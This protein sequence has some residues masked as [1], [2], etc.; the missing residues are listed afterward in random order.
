MTSDVYKNHLNFDD[1]R[2]ST[3]RLEMLLNKYRS[4]SKEA[5]SV[6]KILE[7]L[8][9]KIKANQLKEPV[10]DS[11]RSSGYYFSDT[12]LGEKYTDLCNAYSN[13]YIDVKGMR[14]GAI[15]QK[16]NETIRLALEEARAKR[17]AEKEKE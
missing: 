6:Y 10:E 14:E 15:N 3:E 1:L 13:F 16:I 17:D 9:N 7:P 5:E 4:E 11:F 8:L 2:K 12:P